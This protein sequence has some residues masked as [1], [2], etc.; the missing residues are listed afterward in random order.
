MISSWMLLSTTRAID[1]LDCIGVPGV[2]FADSRAR[3]ALQ[4]VM[5]GVGAE[6]GDVRNGCGN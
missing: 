4:D 3:A 6:F 2:K 5:C 1:G